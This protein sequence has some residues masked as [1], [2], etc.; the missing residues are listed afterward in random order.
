MNGTR[1]WAHSGRLARGAALA[2]PIG[3]GL[4]TRVATIT[5]SASDGETINESAQFM[6]GSPDKTVLVAGTGRFKTTAAQ[7]NLCLLP[8][9]QVQLVN[10]LDADVDVVVTVFWN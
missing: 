4:S 2:L 5:V 6:S 3:F 8:G 10:H 9:N 7:G 1:T